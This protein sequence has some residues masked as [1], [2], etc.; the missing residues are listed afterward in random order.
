MLTPVAVWVSHGVGSGRFLW[1][2]S[3]RLVWTRSQR[4][5]FTA[6]LINKVSRCVVWE[7]S[8]ECQQ[9]RVR[10]YSFLRWK[11]FLW[12]IALIFN[13]FLLVPPEVP[14][15]IKPTSQAI[16]AGQS[17]SSEVCMLSCLSAFCMISTGVELCSLLLFFVIF[18]FYL[19]FFQSDWH[20]HGQKRTPSAKNYLVQK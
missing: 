10:V 17:V 15:L 1:L 19:F 8:A 5:L 14:E 2:D 6:R 16:T 3:Y 20:L 11:G 4:R 9:L 13:C 18:K 12:W 7:T